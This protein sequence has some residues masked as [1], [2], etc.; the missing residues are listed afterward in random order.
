MR[1][2]L[3]HS[4]YRSD[5]PSGENVVVMLQAE[6]LRTAGHEVLLVSRHTDEEMRSR[7][8]DVRSAVRVA[9]G[10]GPDPT[11]QLRRFRPDVVHVHNLFPNFGERLLA[12]W[13]GPLVATLHNFRPVCANALLFREGQ[14]C[15]KCPGVGRGRSAGP[16]L[17]GELVAGYRSTHPAADGQGGRRG[18]G[19]ILVMLSFGGVCR[20]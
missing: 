6:A 8:Y 13:E 18:V 16:V 15:T 17:R 5:A 14:V 11:A 20:D 2:A 1:I 7:L 4:F 3:V 10:V 19:G 9:T 12:S